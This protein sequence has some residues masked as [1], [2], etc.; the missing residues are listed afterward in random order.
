MKREVRATAVVLVA[1]E[2]DA[3]DLGS[4]RQRF[5]EDA[6]HAGL[7]AS[8]TAD[9]VSDDVVIEDRQHRRVRGRHSCA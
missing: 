4:G 5:A 9:G 1:D 7:G 6:N 2:V 3:L 8:I